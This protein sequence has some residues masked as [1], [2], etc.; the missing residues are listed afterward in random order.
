MTTGFI[1]LGIM[2]SRMAA[3]L[4]EH[5]FDLVVHNRTRSKAEALLAAGAAWAASPAEAGRPADV[6][7]TM[8]ADPEAVRAATLGDDGFLDA[9]RPGTCWIDC[10]TV[11]PT[12]S[13]EMAREA[14]A[15]EVGFLD[16]PVGG[17]KGP[18]E[19]GTLMFLVGGDAD[20]VAP[21]QAH[22]DAM[23]SRT[24]P[25]GGPG[26][27]TSMKMVVNLLLGAE[28]AVFAEAMA[29]G[30]GLGI[31]RAGLL[32]ALVGSPVVAPFLQ[33]KKDLIT[34]DAFEPEFPLALMHKDLHLAALT[35]Y[36]ANVAMPVENA[37]KEAFALAARSGLGDLDFSAIYRFLNPAGPAER[38]S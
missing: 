12:F 21:W 8:L 6:L 22:F 32:D 20:A 2:G 18:A 13:R 31:P 3:N 1:G 29:L 25:L 35:A 23:G 33:G 14:A 27:G 28:M 26:M 16:A 36:E 17:T 30:Q 5:G 37:A 24:I 10:S 34:H 19:A 4:Q 38:E 7:F 9:M 15:R 11:N